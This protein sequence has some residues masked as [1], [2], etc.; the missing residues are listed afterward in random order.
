MT[1]WKSFCYITFCASDLPLLSIDGYH[2][3]QLDQTSR[4]FI[5][6]NSA[7]DKTDEPEDLLKW[8]ET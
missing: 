3:A 5:G 7:S 6:V 1:V 4:T 2:D 8:Q